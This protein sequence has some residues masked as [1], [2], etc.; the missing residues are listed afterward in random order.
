[1]CTVHNSVFVAL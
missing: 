1:M